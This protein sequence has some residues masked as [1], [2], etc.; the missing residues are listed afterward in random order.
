MLGKMLKTETVV[1]SLDGA[2]GRVPIRQSYLQKNFMD[3]LLV[4]Q[5]RA[6]RWFFDSGISSQR[7]CLI[8]NCLPPHRNRDNFQLSFVGR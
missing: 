8:E 5:G 1:P 7:K 3:P 4:V 6:R 2:I